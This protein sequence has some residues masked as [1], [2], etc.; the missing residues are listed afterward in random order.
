MDNVAELDVPVRGASV[1]TR[2]LGCLVS[3]D[4]VPALLDRLTANASLVLDTV[5]LPDDDGRALTALRAAR[6][7]L[8]VCSGLAAFL[9]ACSDVDVVLVSD[10]D[11][12]ISRATAVALI[13]LTHRNDPKLAAIQDLAAILGLPEGSRRRLALSGLAAFLQNSRDGVRAVRWDPEITRRVVGIVDRQGRG[14][15][16]KR[17][18][19]VLL[20][21]PALVLVAPVMFLIGLLVRLDSDGPALFIQERCGYR[22]KPFRIFK[23]RTM[24]QNAEALG[25]PHAGITVANDP[26]ITRLGRLLRKARLDELPQLLNVVKGEMSIVGPRP[27]RRFRADE[28]A[29]QIPFYDVRFAEKPGLT[30][31]AQVRRDYP[32]T[33]AEHIIKFMDEFDYVKARSFWFDLKIIIWTIKVIVSLKGV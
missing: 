16:A 29:E 27:L 33:E 11:A 19:D 20:A 1:V 10:R 12:V 25:S 9:E 4:E 21:L 13:E 28:L 8:Q 3:A 26:R 2:T 30:G 17:I 22:A 14:R 7:R 15:R 31:L 24:H 6:P 23:F 5:W 18:L 32:F